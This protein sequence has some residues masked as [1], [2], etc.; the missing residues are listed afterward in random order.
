MCDQDTM[1]TFIPEV[2]EFFEKNSRVIAY[3][4]TPTGLVEETCGR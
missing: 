4:Y 2:V 1:Y 3:G